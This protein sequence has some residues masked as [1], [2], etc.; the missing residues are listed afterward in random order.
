MIYQESITN[1]EINILPIRH[2]SGVIS[3][4][5]TP[6][7][8]REAAELLTRSDILGFDTESRPSFTR[9]VVNRM[10]LVQLSPD[11]PAVLIRINNR[12]VPRELIR[13]L[14]NRNILKVGAAVRDDISGIQ[15]RCPFRAN[16]FIDL[17]HLAVE[18]GISDKSL[19][20]IAA[21]VMGCR[22]SKA[23]RLS[24]WEAR[25]L[26]ASQQKYAATDAW[27]CREI[28]LRLMEHKHGK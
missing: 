10:A 6:E 3:V 21:I 14:E 13:I 9:G 20:K 26:T 1:E 28:Y 16:G 4:V 24:N 8:M 25:E 19:K 11:T 7:Q 27:I 22:L 12:N 17:Q 18:Y 5:D 15:K 23:Q 2:F